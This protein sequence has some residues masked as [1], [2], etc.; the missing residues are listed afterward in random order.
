LDQY[1]QN[2][3]SLLISTDFTEHKKTTTYEVENPGPG[4]RQA[5][6]Y[7]GVKPVNRILTLP[8]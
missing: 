7:G 4:V 3:Q 5:P 8:Y 1:Q 2:K 6:P